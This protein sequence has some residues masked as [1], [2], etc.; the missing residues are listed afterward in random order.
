QL[1]WEA[2]VVEYVNCISKLITVNGNSKKSTGPAPLPKGIPIIGPRFV[3]PGFLDIQKRGGLNLQPSCLYI[4]P[5]NIIHP[6]YYPSITTCPQCASKNIQWKGWTGAGSREVHG[7][8]VEEKA[9]GYQLRCIPCGE[10]YGK[11]GTDFGAKNAEGEKLGSS[12]STTNAIF[13]DHW[14]HWKIPRQFLSRAGLI[15]LIHG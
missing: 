11:D 5:L 15:P 3:P 14:E 10:K 1:E 8:R 4:R 7:L 12:F 13:W 2:N 6:F 9:L